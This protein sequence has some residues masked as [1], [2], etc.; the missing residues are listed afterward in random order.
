M[1]LVLV[2]LISQGAS[3]WVIGHGLW[4]IVE[5]KSHKVLELMDY[6]C[7]WEHMKK[8]PLFT[9]LGCIKNNARGQLLFTI[10]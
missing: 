4:D 3:I 2:A 6:C 10:I 9:L 7:D 5:K 8:K 1:V